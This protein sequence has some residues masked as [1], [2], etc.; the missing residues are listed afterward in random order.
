MSYKCSILLFVQKVCFYPPI[1][2]EKDEVNLV[3]NNPGLESIVSDNIR[4][5]TSTVLI[6]MGCDI[7]QNN[8]YIY[9]Y[10][11]YTCENHAMMRYYS[12]SH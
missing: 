1:I 8:V 4:S 5:F 9:I 11:Y 7:L 10:I 2:N 3:V 12:P 6:T